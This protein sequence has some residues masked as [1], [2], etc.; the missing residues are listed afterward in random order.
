MQAE[1]SSLLPKRMTGYLALKTVA[2]KPRFLN[3]NR[4][5]VGTSY[6]EVEKGKTDNDHSY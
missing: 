2:R 1:K 5:S 3:I 4:K 6:D